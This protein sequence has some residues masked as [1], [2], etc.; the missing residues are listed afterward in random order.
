MKK[1]VF[2]TFFA[3]VSTAFAVP[4]QSSVP[5]QSWVVCR[6]DG[7]Y[8]QEKFDE[9]NAKGFCNNDMSAFG[10]IENGIIEGDTFEKFVEKVKKWP[11]NTKKLKLLTSEEMQQ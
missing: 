4:A 1:I 10:S 3:M 7:S 8:K 2:F 11:N 6:Q 9:E 5:D